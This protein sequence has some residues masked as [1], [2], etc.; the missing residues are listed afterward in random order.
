MRSREKQRSSLSLSRATSGSARRSYR[1]I[2][3]G[4]VER[5]SIAV[6]D[7]RTSYGAQVLLPTESFKSQLATVY[8]F[9]DSG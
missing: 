6:E 7:Y 9:S 1:G 2:T 3:K 5:F 8:D 4:S